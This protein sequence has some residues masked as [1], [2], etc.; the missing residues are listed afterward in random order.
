MAL[1]FTPSFWV[2]LLTC[3][4]C[5][6]AQIDRTVCLRRVRA[7]STKLDGPQEGLGLREI[8]ARGKV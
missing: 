4:L 7:R 5:V 2:E 3:T 1:W 6:Y 8:G